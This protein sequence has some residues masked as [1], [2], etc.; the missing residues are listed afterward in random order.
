MT[1]TLEQVLGDYYGIDPDTFEVERI[2]RTAYGTLVRDGQ[3][4]MPRQLG[5]GR[6]AQ[7]EIEDLF[8]LRDVVFVPEPMRGTL[9]ERMIIEELKKQAAEARRQMPRERR[10]HTG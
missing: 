10:R 4:F 5:A 8:G 6:S 9:H 1:S 3:E 7:M 2:S